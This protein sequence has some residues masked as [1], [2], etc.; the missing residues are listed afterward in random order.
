VFARFFRLWYSASGKM[1]QPMAKDS[2]L[3]TDWFIS[4]HWVC[5][6]SAKASRI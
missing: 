3:K 5:I 2:R 1:A 6:N 4:D